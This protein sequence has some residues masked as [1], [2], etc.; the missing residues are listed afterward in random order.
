[1]QEGW[2]AITLASQ[3]PDD[4][5]SGQQWWPIAWQGGTAYLW[6]AD[7]PGPAITGRGGLR[8]QTATLSGSIVPLAQ[9]ASLMARCVATD[10]GLHYF[11][12][13]VVTALPNTSTSLFTSFGPDATGTL[14]AWTITPGHEVAYYTEVNLDRPG[15]WWRMEDDGPVAVDQVARNHGLLS[16]TG[17]TQ[18]IPSPIVGAPRA[19]GFDGTGFAKLPVAVP[20]GTAVGDP[21]SFETWF[22]IAP[23][24]PLGVDGVLLFS[25]SFGE[26]MAELGFNTAGNLYWASNANNPLVIATPNFRDGQWHHVV[27]SNSGAP[28][29]TITIYVDGTSRGTSFKTL[30]GFPG[31]R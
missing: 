13:L 11:D 2:P 31:T 12:S 9:T 26:E 23:S 4:Q 25:N 6:V 15:A 8:P 17:V 28:T 16:A 18:G 22:Q 10:V 29:N 1:M 5:Q 21:W 20:V 27:V 30:V 3:V 24:A 7:A 19:T 14:D